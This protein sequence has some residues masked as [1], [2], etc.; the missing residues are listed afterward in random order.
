MAFGLPVVATTVA[1]EGMHLQHGSD[2]LVADDPADFAAAV[3]AA[4]TDEGL[5]D[6]LSTNGLANVERHF[7]PGKA[8]ATLSAILQSAPVA[9]TP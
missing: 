2:V 5:W 1:V 8:S 3:V 9:V 6:R 7:S 4:Y